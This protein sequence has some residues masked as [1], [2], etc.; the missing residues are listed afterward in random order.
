M[1]DTQRMPDHQL[2]VGGLMLR[3]SWYYALPS[4]ALKAGAMVHRT[5]LGEPVLVGRTDDGR[6]FALVGNHPQVKHLLA[7]VSQR[8]GTSHGVRRI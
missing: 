1:N 4:H 6:A 7:Q 2:G 8:L 3:D 5:L